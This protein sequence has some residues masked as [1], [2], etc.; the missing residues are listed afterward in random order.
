MHSILL[1][2]ISAILLTLSVAAIESSYA[3]PL[4]TYTEKNFT[5]NVLGIPVKGSASFKL[6][7]QLN[8]PTGYYLYLTN[9][10]WEVSIKSYDNKFSTS[11]AMQNSLTFDPGYRSHPYDITSFN[12]SG[13]WEYWECWGNQTVDQL[14]GYHTNW[15]GRAWPSGQAWNLLTN[16]NY[17]PTNILIDCYFDSGYDFNYLGDAKFDFYDKTAPVPEPGTLSMVSYCILFS[18]FAYS[19]KRVNYVH[20]LKHLYRK[21]TT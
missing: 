3:L 13:Y 14:T 17:L 7:Y 8:D 21:T 20:I 5:G 15:T 1:S 18:V 4:P 11:I 16:Q 6:L 9:T 10:I 19:R 12:W 2:V